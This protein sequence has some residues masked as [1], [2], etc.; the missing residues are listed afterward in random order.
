MRRRWR[1][2]GL[3]A[4][5]LSL[6]GWSRLGVANL[7]IEITSGVDNPIKVAIVPF[8]GAEG[9]DDVAGIVSG[10]L[11]RTGQ[12][13]AIARNNM[14]STPHEE[15]EVVMRD[16][17]LL[18]ADYVAI[19]QLQRTANGQSEVRYLLFNTA[20]G[21]RLLAEMLTGRSDQTRALAHRVSDRIYEA[22][23]GIPGIFS[24]QMIYITESRSAGAMRYRLFLADADG[25]RPQV[26]LDSREPI[27]SPAWAPDGERIAYVSFET[28]RPAIYVQNVRSGQREQVTNF[29]GLN[30]APDWSPDGR[31]LALVLSKDGDP[32]IYILDLAT[33][34][35]KRVTS[36]FAIDTEPRWL[37][38]GESLIFTSNRG[39]KPQIYQ[40]DLD[41]L[42]VKRVT[43][44]GDYNARGT[45]TADGRTLV[46]VHRSG[47]NFHIAAQDLKRGNVRILSDTR[48]DESPSVSP[49]GTMVLYATE[50][51]GQGILAA[52]S[53]DGRVRFRIPAT[54][55]D[56]REPA[57]SPLR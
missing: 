20:T 38:D 41:S 46:F 23:T 9:V 57:W 40:L 50:T 14:L 31:R 28:G 30:S 55:G 36:H 19:G 12:F 15:Q 7:T 51:R 6:L 29:S 4:L 8:R 17:R 49:N 32:E 47:G 10:D 26:L 25:E 16:W 34:N 18:G 42:A 52:V 24:T 3:L 48:L 33:R 2:F 39:G 5:L 43:Y 27:L 11:E 22:I 1:P 54:E 21:A 45:V 13:S 44:E 56:V 53:I 35:L 37:P